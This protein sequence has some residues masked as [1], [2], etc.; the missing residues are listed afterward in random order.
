MCSMLHARNG[1][2]SAASVAS[3]LKVSYTG[4][5]VALIVGICGGA[6]YPST[7]KQV[8]LGDVIMSDAVVEYDFGR[9]YPGDF[10]RKTDVKDTLGRPNREIR[11][12]LA[13]LK[14]TRARQE[15]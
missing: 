1:E 5:Q 7:E 10:Q 12:L 9:Q 15:F 4:I 8:F 6:L 11:T 14:A 2:G 3:T 13:N